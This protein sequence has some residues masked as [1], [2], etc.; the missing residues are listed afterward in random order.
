MLLIIRA[1]LLLTSIH[2]YAHEASRIFHR[3]EQNIVNK[4]HLF[5]SLQGQVTP[6]SIHQKTL[7]SHSVSPL[8]HQVPP[9]AP[10]PVT[11]IP[12]P[13]FSQRTFVSHNTA[14]LLGSHQKRPPPPPMLNGGTSS[15]QLARSP[16]QQS[17]IGVSRITTISNSK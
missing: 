8:R 9:S 13:S 11:Y 15:P 6:S 5:E 1:V 16:L 14:P 4:H 12:S 7:A 3:E 2:A 10:N 17:A